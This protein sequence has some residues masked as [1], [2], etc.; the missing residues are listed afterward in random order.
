[1][2]L[3]TVSPGRSQDSCDPE[4]ESATL[5]DLT[6][7]VTGSRVDLTLDDL[8]EGASMTGSLALD[9]PSTLEQPTE[10]DSSSSP[11]CWEWGP[12]ARMEVDKSD[13]DM[14]YEVTIIYM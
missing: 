8:R 1:M 13:D 3:L 12:A 10:C 5:D 14:C 2:A 7:T 11:I 4:P 6:V 9:L